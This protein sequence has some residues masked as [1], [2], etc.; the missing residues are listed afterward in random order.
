MI[1]RVAPLN[2][3]TAVDPGVTPEIT[4]ASG[5]RIEA[6]NRRV[7]L[8]DVTGG[9]QKTVEGEIEIYGEVLTYRPCKLEPSVSP[10]ACLPVDLA[11][12]HD[13]ELVIEAGVV[14]GESIDEVDGS[15]W[16]DEPIRWPFRLWF[17]TR[18]R[19]RVRGAYLE[20]VEAGHRIYVLFSQPMDP[21]TSAGE[22]EVL[23]LAEVALPAQNPIWIDAQTARVDMLSSLDPAIPYSLR[24]GPGA[25]S[26]TNLLLDGN[27][28]GEP[29]EPDDRFSA[30]F[31]GSQLVIRSRMGDD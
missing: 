31:T 21:I 30:S 8:Y 15:E 26:S 16:P 27:D 6:D 19:P 12:D 18:D 14:Q 1:A 13:F 17:S 22:I 4:F 24:V 5:A 23:D 20:S 2:G 7:V 3:V 25:R 10:P 11:R 9:G 29:G 28:N